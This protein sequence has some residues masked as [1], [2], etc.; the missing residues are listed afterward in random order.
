M[1]FTLFFGEAIPGRANLT[2]KEWQDFMTDT[3]SANL[4]DG[5]TVLNANGAWMSPKTRRT[6]REATKLLMVALPIA[7]D[8]TTAVNRIRTEYQN[9]FHQQL[10]GLTTQQAC[11]AF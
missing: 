4:P 6:V 9:R 11:G 1:V 8:S 3:V 5:Y 7:P 2:D 10:V